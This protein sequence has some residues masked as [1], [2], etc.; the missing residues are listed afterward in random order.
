MSTST[1]DQRLIPT[2]QYS[3]PAT[4]NTVTVNNTG[5]VSLLLNP[6]GTLATL[7]VTLPSGPSD[8]DRISVCS[9]QIVTGLTMNGGTVI[10][11]LT[12]MAVGTFASYMFSATASSWFRIA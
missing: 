1:I 4:G 11:A 9:S 12:T 3:T 2:V 5:Y 10:G 6:A 8:G 7:I